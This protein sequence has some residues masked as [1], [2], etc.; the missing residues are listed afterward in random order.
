MMWIPESVYTGSLSSPTSKAYLVRTAA[1]HHVKHVML[2]NL[3]QEVVTCMSP[4]EV[5]AT[6][7]FDQ[8]KV[9]LIV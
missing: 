1:N 3:T 9:H 8:Q 2:N 4:V 5:F 6:K 7:I